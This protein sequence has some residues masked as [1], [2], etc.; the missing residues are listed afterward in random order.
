[1]RLLVLGGTHHVGRAVVETALARGDD[2]TTLN[3]GMTGHQPPGAQARHADRT[4]PAA[5]RAALGDDT[6][7]AVVDTWSREPRVV[8]DAAGLLAGRAGH[9][10]YVSS[11]SVYSEP[12]APG[13]DESA[14]VV[15][16]DPASADRD[17]YAAAKRG[18]ELAAIEAFGDRALLARAG[19]IIGPYEGVGRMPWWLGRMARGGD[20][21][22]PGPQDQPVQ[23]IDCRDLAAWLLSAADQGVGGAFNTVCRRGHVTMGS[24]LEACR[25]VTGS[26]ARLVWVEP[27]VIVAAGIEPWIQ[28]P[29]W[30]PPTSEYAGLHDSDVSAA[31]AAG[32]ACRPVEETIAATWRWLQDEGF[33]PPG[34]IEHGLDPGV[35]R[36]VLADVAG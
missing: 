20:V 15:D 32:L 24:L 26:G 35:E 21:L 8:A 14:P 5:L 2:V 11:L 33:P 3:R 22:A 25:D 29:I 31:Y 30:L 18:G 34:R 7:D 4:D 27:E 9:Y 19:L 13:A 1:M 6:W 16:A 12:L 28:L 23:V 36:Q 17:D 10:G